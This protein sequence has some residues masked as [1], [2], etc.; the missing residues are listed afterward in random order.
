MDVMKRV[1]K[2][3]SK[4]GILCYKNKFNDMNDVL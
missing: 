2:R 3:M 1:V 4:K